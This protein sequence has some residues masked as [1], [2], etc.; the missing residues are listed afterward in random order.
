MLSS[1]YYQQI[2]VRKR[3]AEIHKKVGECVGPKNSQVEVTLGPGLVV[4]S[5]VL[6][7]PRGGRSS[8]DRFYPCFCPSRDH[9]RLADGVRGCERPSQ[10]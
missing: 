10:E 8:S 6:D 1:R 2:N 3:T 9:N 4:I 5:R 7:S